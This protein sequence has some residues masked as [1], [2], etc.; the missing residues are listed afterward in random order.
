M[1]LQ[2]EA[3]K[4]VGYVWLGQDVTRRKQYAQEIEQANQAMSEVSEA[5]RQF[6]DNMSHELRTPLTAIIGYSDVLHRDILHLH[7]PRIQANVQNIRRSGDHLLNI[8]NN[9]LEFSRIEADRVMLNNR[10]FSLVK[11]MHQEVN[12]V[13]Q[14]VDQNKN[15]LKIYPSE[16]L[17]FLEADDDK[18]EFI[19]HALLENAARY[20]NEGQIELMFAHEQ[21]NGV[22]WLRMSVADTGKGMSADEQ[23]HLFEPF[24]QG[25]NSPTRQ[26]GGVGLSMALVHRFCELMGGRITVASAVGVGSVFVVYLPVKLVET[27][28][29]EKEE[30]VII[31]SRR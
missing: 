18:I 30:P 22:D 10:S 15:T 26:Y 1:P 3:G 2:S 8:I 14:L 12:K 28:T 7:H 11:L 27:L 9:I 13:Q 20:T 23:L 4:H 29:I 16:D 25:D 24:N 5:K 21:S 6:M 19:L 17:D 31:T